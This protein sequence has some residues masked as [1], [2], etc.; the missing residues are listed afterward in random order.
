[1]ATAEEIITQELRRATMSDGQRLAILAERD[2][3][4]SLRR[5]TIRAAVRVNGVEETLTVSAHVS[6]ALPGIGAWRIDSDDAWRVT[7]GRSGLTMA[8]LRTLTQVRVYLSRLERITRIGSLD[9]TQD[10]Q[11]GRCDEGERLRHWHATRYAS[12]DEDAA[13]QVLDRSEL[14]ALLEV[15]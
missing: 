12:G 9:W 14:V 7:Q 6:P 1:M 5:G 13:E 8:T 4:F 3:H 10:L 15:Q 11:P 2:R